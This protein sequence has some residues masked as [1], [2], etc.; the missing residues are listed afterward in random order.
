[1]K[2]CGAD[3][4]QGAVDAKVLPVVALAQRREKRRRLAGAERHPEGV[5][6]L[7]ARGRLGGSRAILRGPY[8]STGMVAQMRALIAGATGFVGRRLAPALLEDGFEVRCLA[9]DLEAPAARR[10]EAA[11]CELV[12]EDLCEPRDLD[13]AMAGVGVAYYLV[14][15][16]GSGE[17]YG[18][19]EERIAEEFGRAA[20]AAG[21]GRMIYLGGLGSD[22]ASPHLRSRHATALALRRNGPPLTYF[23]A[24][25]VVGA[26]S[27]S[28][29]L[30]RDIAMRL[31]AIPDPEW[32]RTKTQPIGIRDAISYLR[33]APQLPASAGREIQIGGPGRFTPLQ[34]VDRMAA[35]LGRPHPARVSVPGA[36]PGAV[37][38][39]A[40]AITSADG[41]GAVAAELA[42]GLAT[43]TVVTDPS[44][45]EL[46][47]ITPEPLE[48]SLHRA[49]EE[50]ERASEDAAAD[51]APAG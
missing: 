26:G 15:L 48:V 33:Q 39:G 3:Q 40:D 4:Q 50:E 41:D 10:L 21:V 36:T 25:M 12:L 47:E 44:G 35:A 8:P 6:R 14:H 24:A 19:R 31:P 11:G 1:M 38:A 16:I 37:A 46:F 13:A 28:Y 22:D 45:A 23:R 42:L 32:M 20:A 30:V 27:A 51:A 17:D 34:V 49:I 43:D 2:S 18:E 29:R 5:G 7:Q 9:R